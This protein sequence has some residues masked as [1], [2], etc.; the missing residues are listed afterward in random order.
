MLVNL[1]E[2]GLAPDVVVP[3]VPPLPA[4]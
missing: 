3:G 2:D 1:V 4:R